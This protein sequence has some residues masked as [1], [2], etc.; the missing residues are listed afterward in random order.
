[1]NGVSTANIAEW[2]VAKNYIKNFYCPY[3]SGSACAC[4]SVPILKVELFLMEWEDL[5]ENLWTSP[6]QYKYFLQG[7]WISEPPY[8]LYIK[9]RLSKAT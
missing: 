9:N 2:K 3:I 4:L 8:H 7:S 6:T 5:T 1:M